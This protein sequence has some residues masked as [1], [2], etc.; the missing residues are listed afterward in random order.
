MAFFKFNDNLPGGKLL[1]AWLNAERQS[2]ILGG[3][4]LGNIGV[5]DAA[6]VMDLFG[7]V[8]NAQTDPTTNAATAGKAEIEAAI[9]KKLEPT[10]ITTP[11]YVEATDGPSALGAKLAIEQLLDELL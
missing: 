1:R 11:E 5:M 7:F 9:G 3:Q 4:L 8:E 2:R 6:R 10:E